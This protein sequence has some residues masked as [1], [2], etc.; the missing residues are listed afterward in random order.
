MSKSSEGLDI[1]IKELEALVFEIASTAS[2]S[3]DR[4]SFIDYGCQDDVLTALLDTQDQVARIGWIADHIAGRCGFMQ[5]KGGAEE[6]LLPPAA[7]PRELADKG[8]EA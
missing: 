7:R 3:R 8:E 5:I 1:T 4:D 6:W 2:Q